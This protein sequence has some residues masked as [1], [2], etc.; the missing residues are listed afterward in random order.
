[1]LFVEQ[2]IADWFKKHITQ[3]EDKI[4]AVPP[5]EK[6]NLCIELAG[7]LEARFQIEKIFKVNEDSLLKQEV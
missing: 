1:M 3:S 2:E 6:I 5:A 7:V 4:K